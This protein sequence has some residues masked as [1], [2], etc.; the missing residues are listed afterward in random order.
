[1][2]AAEEIAN[3]PVG[4]PKGWVPVDKETLQHVKFP[5]VFALGDIAAVAMGK[6]GGSARKQYKVVVDNLISA[7][8]G[9]ELTSKYG[10]YTVCPLITSIGTVMLAEF[11]WSKKPTPSFPLDPTQERYIWWLLKVYALKPMT[12]YGM[13]SGRA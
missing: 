10:G 5:N 8:E 3:S 2:I 1:M 9:K 12:Q 11:D 6:T 7:M 4:S 13:L